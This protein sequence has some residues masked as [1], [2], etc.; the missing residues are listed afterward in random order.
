MTNTWLAEVGTDPGKRAR[1]IGSAHSVFVSTHTLAGLGR[2]VRGVVADSWSRSSDAHVLL[3]DA[4]PIMIADDDLLAYRA[5]HPLAQVIGV[6]R[7]LVGTAADDGDH[8]MAV[9][10]AAGRLMWVEGHRSARAQ[11]EKMNFVPGAWWDEAHAGTNAP[12][13]ALALDHEV[14]IFATEHFLPSVQAWTCAAAPIHDPATGEVLGAIDITGGD[15]V[16]NPLSLGLVRAAAMAAENELARNSGMGPVSGAAAGVGASAA[17]L[18]LRTASGSVRAPG[19]WLPRTRPVF[20]LDALGR[21]EGVC[22]SA[23]RAIRLHRRHTEILIMLAL[24]PDGMTGDQLAATLYDDLANPTTLRVEMT[25]LRRVVGDLLASRPYRLDGPVAADFL[26]VAAALRDKNVAGALAA[27][28]GPLLP[29]SE[30]PGVVRQ[31][32]WLDTQ[33]RSAVLTSCDADLVR[34]WAD[35]AGFEDLQVWEHLFRIAPALSAHRV[36][37]ASRTQRLRDEY[38]LSPS[39]PLSPSLSRNATFMQRPRR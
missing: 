29:T 38:G 3:D 10:D 36:V 21:V 8:V 23:G 9:S 35:R 11:A 31:R 17:G 15:S 18:G 25:R 32:E 12:G 30:A 37:A 27:Y 2:E 14:Q 24:R 5:A 7:R 22:Q 16:A 1:E 6:L 28:G 19:L 34:S 33:L 26:E 39:P 20:R 4:P 13:T